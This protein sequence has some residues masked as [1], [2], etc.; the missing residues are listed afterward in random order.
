MHTLGQVLFFRRSSCRNMG[1]YCGLEHISL[2]PEVAE[3]TIS[4]LVQ[5]NFLVSFLAEVDAV[6]KLALTAEEL[7]SMAI[8]VAISCLSAG[9]SF[10]G[11][12]KSDGMVL[13]LP[14]KVGWGPT[15]GCLVLVRAMEVASRILA[16]NIIQLS[17]RGGWCGH[18]GGPLAVFIFVLASRL[19]FPEAKLVDVLVPRICGEKWQTFRSRKFWRVEVAARQKRYFSFK[20]A[21][22]Q[23]T[24]NVM[25]AYANQ[26]SKWSKSE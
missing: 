14:G 26:W 23:I 4:A 20:T 21:M 3:S 5:T 16:F 8:S 9:L 10:A 17:M 22:S 25:N 18:V 1:G 11:R 2:I 15:M 12:D 13:S 6:A 24:M 7:Q 19:C